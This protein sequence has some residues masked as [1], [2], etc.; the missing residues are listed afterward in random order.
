[1]LYT[2]PGAGAMAVQ[3]LVAGLLGAVI[4]TRKLIIGGLKLLWEGKGPAKHGS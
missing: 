1:M 4:K 3:F 2:D